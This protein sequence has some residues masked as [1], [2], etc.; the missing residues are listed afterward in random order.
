MESG[1]SRPELNDEQQKAAFC[2][3]NAVIAAGAGSGKT[4][5]LAN[6]F[7]WLLT[8]KDCRVNEIL[9]L[10]FTQ[11][12]AA[13]MY[14]RI[15]DLLGE[16]AEE[17]T[18]IRGDRARRAL[19][20][21]IR[22]RIQTL[23]SYSASLVR[24][25]A[26]RYGITPDFTIDQD[27]CWELALEESLPFLITRRRHPAIERLYPDNKPHEIAH[28]IF[29]RVL[30]DFSDMSREIGFIHNL[31]IQFDIIRAEWKK[32]TD[33]IKKL[34]NDLSE[35][36]SEKETLLPELV[37]LISVYQ[38][39]RITI[40]EEDEIQ[41]YF[42]SLPGIPADDLVTVTE[43]HPLRGIII[44]LLG[45]LSEISGLNLRKA[46]KGDNPVKKI[47]Y[48]FRDSIWGEF[49]SLAVFC[50]QAGLVF[51]V[52]LLL[53]ELQQRYLKKK[54]AEG[55]LTFRDVAY[56]ARTILLEQEDIRKSEKSAFK[57]IMID[58]FQD[59]N[60]LQKEL[61]FLLA[62]KPGV[63]RKHVPGAEDLSPGKLFFVGDEKQ[64]IY[65]FRGADVSVFRKLKAELQSKD[66]PLKT[67]YRS[68]PNLIGAFNA[69]FGGS[70]FDPQGSSPLHQGPSVFAPFTDTADFPPYEAAYTPL[71]AGKDGG[72]KLTVCILDK[73]DA[74]DSPD[75]EE[76][77][78]TTENEARYVA[79]RIA[80]LLRE[81]DSEGRPKYRPEDI[82][83]L[84]RARSPQYLFERHLRQLNI[85]YASE[86]MN[87]FFF[88]GPVNDMMSVLRLA[89]YPLDTAAYAEML[90]SPFAGLSIPGLAVCLT[91][92]NKAKSPEPFT[93]DP[94]PNLTEAD[95]K[96][97][98]NGQAL[99]RHIHGKA[100]S[101]SVSSLVTELWY[102]QGYRYETEWNPQTA[103]YRELHDY[104]FHLA[105]QADT[106]SL[107]LA[108][109]TD[110]LLDLRDSGE[111]LTDI[112]IPMERPGA[113]HLLTIHKSKGLEFPVVFLCCCGKRSQAG[114]G[115]DVFDT[116]DTGITFC[117]PLPPQCVEMPKIKNNFFWERCSTEEKR[118]RTAELRR[119]LYV[120]MTR[121]EKELYLT[122]CI[123]LTPKNEEPAP[124]FSER[125]KK[126]IDGKTKGAEEK[127]PVPGD[128][129]FNDDTFF[130]LF[131]P[132]ASAHLLPDDG[133]E[134]APFFSLEAIPAY[135]GDYIKKQESAS[136][137]L[138][139]DQKGL[140][141]FFA[142]TGPVY[143][144]AK[145]I[146]TP[147]L[148][149]NHLTPTSLRQKDGA[150]EE[151]SSGKIFIINREYSG[152]SAA[153]VFGK[154]DDMLARYALDDDESGER[155]NSGGFGTIAH[156]C[157]EALLNGM[158]PAIPPSLAG[159]L[160]PKEADAFLAAG[161]ELAARF[162]RSPLG[163][164]AKAAKMRES[165][166]SF[167]NL[168][169][170]P[171]GNG[172]FISG[173]VDL[174]FEGE[175]AIHVV[176][177]KTDNREAPGEHTAQM[178]CY[179]HAAFSL[180]AV[181][182]KKDCRVW[183]YYLRTGHAVEMTDRAKQ[184]SLE[185]NV[186]RKLNFLPSVPCAKN[187]GR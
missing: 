105:V 14:R 129:I 106:G 88:G 31:K 169:K 48:Q 167:R 153:D 123:T 126:Y 44:T 144:N 66:M 92:F 51:S 135:T 5:V 2:A 34:L 19:D 102:N 13:Q 80:Q 151:T 86:D 125:L 173:T 12:A 140:N 116:G 120:G 175:D 3:E 72:G 18:G 146:Q 142:K 87:S 127:N 28:R 168:V 37:P 150:A 149:D 55:I 111:R 141:A 27:R 160:S 74:A 138:P 23:D 43:S 40:P 60:E 170:D 109:F 63:M 59:N 79:E 62:E 82:A 158:E 128:A 108:A 67:N 114:S 11:K 71:A 73:Q 182:A 6:R 119:L 180:F 77:I 118:K 156:A 38:S 26:S 124:D 132:A 155:F 32:Y 166:F 98:R 131:L 25:C 122:G 134:A 9:T 30:F 36:I 76:R 181:P 7:A 121:A 8:E 56:L 143:R 117:P 90:R 33:L 85:P 1:K 112:E 78:D 147:R 139:N 130:G 46:S 152:Q 20:D 54:R 53:E 107:G 136:A 69:I 164:I 68:A 95:Q 179:Y 157:A 162:V 172:A 183:L 137:A 100:R 47:I 165:E 91:I 185:R 17:D 24:Q 39:G 89:A 145:R 187:G 104:L 99:Y 22:A 163:E 148:R 186:L 178:A 159:F 52:M 15:H 133:R 93:D 65:L 16:I 35:F 81:K 97:Y 4:M 10:T 161:T 45:F 110:S 113:V 83:I 41:K 42:D 177:F 75:D 101:E 184:F 96:K 103:V 94:I 49:S 50:I 154:V 61:L 64:S 84:F 171:G 115:G 21:F 174:L 57:A 176:E 70:V 29:A 58:E